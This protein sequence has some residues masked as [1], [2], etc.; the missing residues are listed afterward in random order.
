MLYR[1][2]IERKKRMYFQSIQNSQ[3]AGGR[4][5][6]PVDLEVSIAEVVT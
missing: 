6:T 2:K 3:T 5:Y 4:Y 1:H